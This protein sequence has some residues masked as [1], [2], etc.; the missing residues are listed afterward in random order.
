MCNITGGSGKEEN[1]ELKSLLDR[2]PWAEIKMGPPFGSGTYRHAQHLF[3]LFMLFCS[4]QFGFSI[5]LDDFVVFV[6]RARATWEAN[7]I[8]RL[9]SRYRNQF[10]SEDHMVSANLFAAQC[11]P[12]CVSLLFPSVCAAPCQCVPHMST[13]TYGSTLSPS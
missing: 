11:G 12:C 7:K 13:F 1:T 10:V 4:F 8:H 5:L 9:M 6:E 2:N 3:F